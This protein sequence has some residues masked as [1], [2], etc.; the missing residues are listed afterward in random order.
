VISCG[1]IGKSGEITTRVLGVFGCEG[2]D[3]AHCGYVV[4]VGWIDAVGIAG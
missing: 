3:V 1:S 2:V 4:V